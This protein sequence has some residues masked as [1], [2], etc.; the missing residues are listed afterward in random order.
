MFQLNGLTSC[1]IYREELN[2]GVGIT[3]DILKLQTDH[4]QI[5]MII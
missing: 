3:L 2:I 1:K 5:S 4:S